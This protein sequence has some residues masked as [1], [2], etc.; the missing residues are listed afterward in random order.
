M[1]N[2]FSEKFPMSR[3]YRRLETSRRAMS[4]NCNCFTR[5]IIIYRMFRMAEEVDVTF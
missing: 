3:R 4:N 5:R 1:G 2:T